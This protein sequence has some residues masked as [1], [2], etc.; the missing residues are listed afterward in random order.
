MSELLEVD[1]L[2]IQ[3]GVGL[4]I[5]EHFLSFRCKDSTLSIAL[6]CMVDNSRESEIRQQ[7]HRT[8]FAEHPHII[9]HPN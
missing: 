8:L 2:G 6:E 4:C 9:I 5:Q 1:W 3:Q 7:A